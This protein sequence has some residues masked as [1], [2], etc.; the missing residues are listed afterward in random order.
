MTEWMERSGQLCSIE[1][2]ERRFG[3]DG[4]MILPVPNGMGDGHGLLSWVDASYVNA[5]RV[6]D[7][8]DWYDLPG[9]VQARWVMDGYGQNYVVR[10]EVRVTPPAG[11]L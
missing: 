8:F 3:T 5:R 6:A 2:K 9:G 4:F 7:P 10:R 11:V 1:R